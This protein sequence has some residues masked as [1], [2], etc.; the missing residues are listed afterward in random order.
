MRILIG[1]GHGADRWVG[2]RRDKGFGN[3]EQ[4]EYAGLRLRTCTAAEIAGS[5]S[6]LANGIEGIVGIELAAWPAIC[7]HIRQDA[8]DGGIAGVDIDDSV[9]VRAHGY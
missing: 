9:F 8:D 7:I 6:G 3:L 1:V 5:D 2:I 4:N